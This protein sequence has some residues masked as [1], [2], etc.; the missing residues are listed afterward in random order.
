[1]SYDRIVISSGHGKHVAGAVG[2]L[3]EHAEAVR[4]VDQLAI[5]LGNRGVDV[6][7]FEDTVSTTQNENLNRIVDFHNSQG[8]HD[9][10][11]SVHFNA[12][13]ETTKPMG[14]EVL[15]VTQSALAGR[16][17]LAIADAGDFLNRGAKPRDDLF[18]LNNTEQPA[19]LIEVCFVDSSADADGYGSHFSEICEAIAGALGAPN[20]EED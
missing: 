9:L 19:I 7:T 4:V 8:P 1:M 17:S 3:N 2:I 18:F 10:D 14:T 15:Y 5:E 11:I 13:V 12:Y 6:T 16:V 20:P